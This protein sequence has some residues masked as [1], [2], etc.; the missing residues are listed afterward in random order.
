MKTTKLAAS[1]ADIAAHSPSENLGEG[2]RYVVLADLRMGD[3]GKKDELVGS[4]KAL[5]A[6]LGRWYL[7]QGYTLVLNGDVEDLRRFWIKDILAAWPEMYALFDAFSEKGRLRK[8]V[9][10]RDLSLLRLRSYPYEVHHGFRLDGEKNSILVLHGHQASRPYVGR[11]YLS[12]YIQ[13]WLSSSKRPKP[14]RGGK[15]RYARY[16]AE[17]FLYRAASRLGVAAIVGHTKRPLFE[18]STNRAFAIA[19]AERLFR[20]GDPRG[21]DSMVDAL[22]DLCRKEAK[23]RA[24]D[25]RL[26]LSGP[27]YAEGE[28][29]SPCLFC[30]GRV[31]GSQSLRALEIE[32]GALRLTRWTKSG[33]E[34]SKRLAIRGIGRVVPEA[35]PE[36]I[37]QALEGTPY[38]RVVTRSAAIRDVL[39]RVEALGRKGGEELEDES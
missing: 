15:D 37:P 3:G 4:K 16:K 7:P 13:Y 17:R 23:R 18:S 26:A 19:E 1:M 6:I 5:Y 21:D 38:K 12:D 14:S 31:L 2:S 36:A 32:G 27:G 39:D 28:S 35:A 24:S 22:I 29:A 30:P 34:A 10:E 8:I 33:R 9:G 11:D 25:P 20:E